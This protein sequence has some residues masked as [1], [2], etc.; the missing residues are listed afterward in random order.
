MSLRLRL[1]LLNA[2]LILL[3]VGAFAG[4][5]YVRQEQSLQRSLDASLE[6]QAHFFSNNA[7][8]WFDLGAG[9][10]R[11]SFPNPN[12]F[13]APETFVQI[14]LRDGSTQVR[15]QN[16][17]GDTLPSNPDLLRN[18]VNGQESFSNIELADQPF[19]VLS[20]PLRATIPDQ[21][22]G[23]RGPFREPPPQLSGGDSSPIGMIQVARPLGP[24]QSSLKSLQ[25][26]L[27]TV[28]AVSL[29]ASL[30]LVWLLARTALAPI[31]RLAATAQA[32]GAARDFTRR[33]PVQAAEQ[34]D[35]VGRLAEAFNQMLDQLQ[36]AY[37]QLETALEA[38]RR[39]VADASHEMRTPLTSLRGNLDLLTQ[40]NA[41]GVSGDREEQQELLAD[42]A[43]ET[44]RLG[45]LVND[46]LLL[47]RADAGQH[48]VLGPAE[49]GPLLR[50][51][52][53]A[54]RFFREAVALALD[55]PPDAW[56]IGDG[57]RLKQLL[58][59]L[60]DNAMKYTPE[61][62]QVGLGA[63]QA[64]RRGVEGVEIHVSDTG[65]GIPAE[66]QERIFER[67]YR[68]DRARGS[69]GAGLGLAI[70]RWI[71]DEHQGSITVQSAPGEG[72]T[73]TVWLPAAAR[74][75]EHVGQAPSPVPVPN[76]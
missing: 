75:A 32:I 72:S 28:G 55:E 51:A 45:R 10:P 33:V 59:I 1:T 54:A 26:S 60:L 31:Q 2:L 11:V 13:A 39:F 58:L 15:S 18:A 46:L 63:R 21:P 27:I 4:V 56:V 76:A 52:F 61:G 62:G 41:A 25:S 66:E 57:D 74:S 5:A 50:D 22:P 53:R 48:L 65:T 24:I 30:I 43:A 3:T 71:V 17:E 35:E 64:V 38:Q 8:V 42:M 29:V 6:E 49:I 67:F 20:A 73:F 44:E 70:A 9:R 69:A 34:R 36:A 37:D 16:L 14:T 40:A 68:I 47:A 12:R 19:R 23:G 7:S